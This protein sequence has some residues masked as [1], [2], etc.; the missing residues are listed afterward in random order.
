[1]K[2]AISL[3][4]CVLICLGIMLP[5]YAT[6]NANKI[7]PVEDGG[8][9]VITLDIS[10]ARTAYTKNATKTGTYYN[11][12]NVAIFK[13]TLDASFY[14]DYGVSSRATGASCDVVLYKSA[15]SIIA[16]NAYTSGSKAYAYTG[17]DYLGNTLY[18]ELTL[19]CDKYG[20]IT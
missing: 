5:V 6:E 15:A 16:E 20:N 3:L 9:F 17:I 19:N 18:K 11:A 1:M 12:S 14:Y 13:I 4:L 7:I 8:Y 2:K 10:D